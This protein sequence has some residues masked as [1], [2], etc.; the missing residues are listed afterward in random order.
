MTS[1]EE[2]C[3]REDEEDRLETLARR[4]ERLD[5]YITSTRYAL[6][7]DDVRYDFE[8]GNRYAERAS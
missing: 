5:N 1:Y 7:E 6:T 3:A 8:H 4:L 2:R